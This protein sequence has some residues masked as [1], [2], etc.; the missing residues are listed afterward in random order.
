MR[1]TQLDNTFFSPAFLRVSNVFLGLEMCFFFCKHKF[2]R[3]CGRQCV[4]SSAISGR[5][6]VSSSI[7]GVM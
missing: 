4:S 2:L 6:P 1:I 7:I 3:S 5:Q